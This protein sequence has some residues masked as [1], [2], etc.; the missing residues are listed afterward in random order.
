MPWASVTNICN[1]AALQCREQPGTKI[2]SG[3]DKVIHSRWRQ[4]KRH[5]AG[6][7]LLSVLFNLLH[8]SV[9]NGNGSDVYNV[10]HTTL[11]VGEVDRLVQTHLYRADNLSV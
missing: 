2:K 4:N 6:M 5:A 8:I 3:T 1:N 9:D 11:K 7:I 10:A